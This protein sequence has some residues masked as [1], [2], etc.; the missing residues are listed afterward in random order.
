MD[1][2]PGGIIPAAFLFPCPGIKP[3]RVPDLDHCFR[4]PALTGHG[5]GE[6]QFPHAPAF[7]LIGP[8]THGR[9]HG[10][11]I[12]KTQVPQPVDAARQHD[13][14]HAPQ[15]FIDTGQ[16]GQARFQL[17][18]CRMADAEFKRRDVAGKALPAFPGAVVPAPV[19]PGGGKVHVLAA[20]NADHLGHD[21]GIAADERVREPG[22]AQHKIVDA[23]RP[24]QGQQLRQA[25][26]RRTIQQGRAEQADLDAKGDD[27][28]AVSDAGVRGPAPERQDAAAQLGAD[29]GDDGPPVVGVVVDTEKETACRLVFLDQPN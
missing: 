18:A 17:A 5:S 20:A 7:R 29:T 28:V 23:A 4:S 24:I 16:A 12:A 11:M 13:T 25:P 6:G 19:I 8:Q 21:K 14:T 10:T 15:P 27:H 22:H 26:E 9:A 2:V 3:G 1:G